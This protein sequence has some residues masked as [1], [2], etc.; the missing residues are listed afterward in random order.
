[1]LLLLFDK[2]RVV[3][4]GELFGSGVEAAAHCIKEAYVE[5]VLRGD[6]GKVDKKKKKKETQWR[7][8]AVKWQLM[9]WLR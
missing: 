9:G 1:L 2:P 5:R 8:L 6:T 4:G 3:F 7:W